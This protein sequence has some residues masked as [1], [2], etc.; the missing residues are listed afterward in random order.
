MAWNKDGKLGPNDPNHSERILIDWLTTPGN[1][2]MFR[3]NDNRG[4]RKRQYALLIANKIK[5]AGVR[6]VRTKKDVI[7]KSSMW[8]VPFGAHTTSPTQKLARD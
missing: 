6:R 7:K 8:K 5:A 3:G 2:S 4:T 1:Y